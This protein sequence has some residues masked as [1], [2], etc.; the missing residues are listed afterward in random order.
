VK[1]DVFFNSMIYLQ[2]SFRI[3]KYMSRKW[4]TALLIASV[5]LLS[6]GVSIYAHVKWFV[7][8]DVS[9]PPMPIGEVLNGTFVKMFLV[10]VAAVYLFFLAD[11]Y[12][13]KQKYLADFDK[14]LKRFDELASMIMRASAGIFFLCLWVWYLVY[15]STFYLTPE[16]KTGAVWVAWLH[17]IMALAVI[18]RQTIFVTG[19]GIFVLYAAALGDFGVFHMLDYI[20]FLGIGV[21]LIASGFSDAKWLKGGFV[22]LFA[23]AGLTLI[24]ASVEKFSYA[25][26]TYPLLEK[27]PDMTMGLDPRTFMTLSGFIEFTVTFIL[28]GAVSVVGRLVSLGMM[29]IFVLAV[30]KFG[31][32][33]AIGH[34]MIVAILFVLLVR[35][36]TDARF[37]LLLPEKSVFTEAYF[38]TGLYFLAFGMIFILYYALHHL[39]FGV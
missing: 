8:H 19:A 11:R 28:L 2:A 39:I 35:G 30:F 27:N 16:L 17:L 3:K 21:F 20:I 13:F 5:Y 22:T 23:C 25:E 31:V 38:M 1:G 6:G 37:M 15:G 29:S 9:K 12:I 18:F 7:E 26:W 24:W 32:V 4:Q 10:S 36:P 14:R 34:L 33:D